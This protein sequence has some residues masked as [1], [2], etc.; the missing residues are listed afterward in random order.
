[1]PSFFEDL[2]YCMLQ[3]LRLP[4]GPGCFERPVAEHGAC[5]RDRRLTER[6]IGAWDVK[7]RWGNAATYSSRF[8]FGDC[9]PRFA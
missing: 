6:R 1:M 4:R 2:H 8:D 5:C 3:R 7:E 9:A